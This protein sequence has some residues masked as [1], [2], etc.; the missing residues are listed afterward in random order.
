PGAP[1]ADPCPPGAP[2]RTYRTSYLQIDM[3]VNGAG[4]HDPQGRLIVLDEDVDA[5]RDGTRPPE[6]FFFRANSGE[7]VVFEATNL[8]PAILEEDDFQVRTPTDTVGQHIHLVKFD[9]PASDGSANGW[10]YEDGTFAPDEVIARIEAANAVGGILGVDG[11]RRTLHPET[12][13]AGVEGAQT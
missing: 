3:V 1:Y 7:C 2:T 12:S 8:M 10:N 13:P 4:W 9:V 11:A 6:P 5:T